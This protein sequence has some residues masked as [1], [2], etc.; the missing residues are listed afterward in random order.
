[1]L[2]EN[3]KPEDGTND[4]KTENQKLKYRIEHLERNLKELLYNDQVFNQ[5]LKIIFQEKENLKRENEKLK[6]RI[7]ILLRN[8]SNQ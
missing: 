1:M 8:F 2:G 3:P 4:L 5:E 7:D 6:Y